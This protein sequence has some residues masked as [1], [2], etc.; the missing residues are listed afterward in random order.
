MRDPARDSIEP[1]LSDATLPGWARSAL[2]EPAVSRPGA[3]LAIMDL[4]RQEPAPRRALVRF[5]RR[6]P[7]LQ[8]PRWPRRGVLSPFGATAIAALFA[9]MLSLQSLRATADGRISGA[10]STALLV[11]ASA[12]TLRD[13]VVP[14]GTGPFG[15]DARGVAAPSL[16][17]TLFRDTL[18]IVE[19]VLRGAGVQSAGVVG[20]FNAWRP[21]VTPMT[22]VADGRWLARVLVPRDM[23]RFAYVVQDRTPHA[24]GDA[25][26]DGRRPPTVTRV[27]L[28]SI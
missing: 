18:R 1:H 16:A 11:Q 9:G 10:D 25:N 19:F 28:D 24:P 23:V 14:A 12:H 17:D 27:R 8:V 22:R 15:L 7:S 2:Q 3:R 21:G 26:T 6:L 13:T 20:D 4:V 5:A